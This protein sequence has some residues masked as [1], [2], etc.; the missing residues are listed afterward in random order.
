MEE[1]FS[2][3]INLYTKPPAS[4][5]FFRKC[6]EYESSPKIRQKM[7][8]RRKGLEDFCEWVGEGL[9]PKAENVRQ[10]SDILADDNA[11]TY[12]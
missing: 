4:T 10:L 9:V 2:W 6:S 7:Q 1:P 12:Y 8:V 11:T 5:R 3:N